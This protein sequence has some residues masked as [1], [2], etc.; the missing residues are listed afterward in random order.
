MVS[1]C[2]YRRCCFILVVLIFAAAG[3]TGTRYCVRVVGGGANK[4]LIQQVPSSQCLQEHDQLV[5]VGECGREVI[6][7]CIS[8]T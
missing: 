2:G 1:G 4:R 8:S 3:V 5:A 6:Y 7:C